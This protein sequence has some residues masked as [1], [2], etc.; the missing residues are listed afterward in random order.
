MSNSVFTFRITN[1]F[2]GF[3]GIMAHFELEKHKFLN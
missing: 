1:G 2:G 3:D